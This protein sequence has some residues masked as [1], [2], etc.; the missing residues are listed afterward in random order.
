MPHVLTITK[1]F[2]LLLYQICIQ[3]ICFVLLSPHEFIIKNVFFFSFSSCNVH[4]GHD[5]YGAGYGAWGGHEHYPLHGQHGSGFLHGPG[6][7]GRLG[8]GTDSGLT[9]P[10]LQT[11]P[12]MLT[13]KQFLATQDDSIS[14]SD[15]ITKYNEYKLEFKR[16]QLN[17][18][19]VAHKDE[20][21]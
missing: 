5:G 15:A 11:Q 19:F 18:F 16:Q 17:E 8:G 4:T 3:V 13:L 1:P 9:N 14:D 20:E 10:D 12:P 6:V 21:W 2:S 7:H